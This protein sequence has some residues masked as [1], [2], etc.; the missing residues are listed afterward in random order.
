MRL[1]EEDSELETLSDAEGSNDDIR[2]IEG[3]LS[4]VSVGTTMTAAL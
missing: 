3:G 1:R 2:A 4:Q